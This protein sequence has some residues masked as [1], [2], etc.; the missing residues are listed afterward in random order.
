MMH[1]HR[2]VKLLIPSIFLLF[3]ISIHCF[4]FPAPQVILSFKTS[5]SINVLAIVM[6]DYQLELI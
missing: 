5:S 6:W 4:T 3:L 1:Q 2:H